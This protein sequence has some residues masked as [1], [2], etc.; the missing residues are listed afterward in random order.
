MMS[1]V[2]IDTCKLCEMAS[3]FNLPTH[4]TISL[5][6]TTFRVAVMEN[7]NQKV[8]LKR[9]RCFTSPSFTEVSRK[10]DFFLSLWSI[11]PSYSEKTLDFLNKVSLHILS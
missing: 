6:K 9:H 11:R 5:K 4:L 1:H 3:F 8:A 10:L 2:P 7:H